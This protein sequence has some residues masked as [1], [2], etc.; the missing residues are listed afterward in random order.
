VLI[1]DNDSEIRQV[2][3]LLL[4]PEYEVITADSADA[5][6]SMFHSRQSVDIILTDQK[7]GLPPKRNGIQ[8]L[9]WVRFNSPRTIRLLMTGFAEL[10]D[11]ID[12][13]NRGHVYHYLSKPWRNDE[14]L[15]VLRNAA[16]KFELIGNRDHLFEQLQLVNRDLELRVGQRTEELEKAN[17]ELKEA[18]RQLEEYAEQQK[19]LALTDPLTGLKNRRMI[20]GMAQAELKRHIRYRNPLTLGIID[21]DHFKDINTVHGLPGGDAILV[22]LA[23]LLTASLRETDSIGRAVDEK[24]LS[25]GRYGGEEFLVIAREANTNGAHILG[26]RICKKVESTPIEYNQKLVPITVSIGLAVAESEVSATYGQMYQ[27]AASALQ[28]AKKEGRNRLIVHSL[29]ASADD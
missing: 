2:L 1:V 17:A 24:F 22:G 19:M 8:L 18:Y 7:M 27:E 10:E 4:S 9:E 5:A 21:V 6:E 28:R 16:E 26:E 25:V 11:T 3:T 20:E 12:A 29:R 13:I 14:V 23:K 15:H